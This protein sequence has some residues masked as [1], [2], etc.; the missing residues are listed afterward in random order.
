MTDLFSNTRQFNP[1]DSSVDDAMQSI[2][3]STSLTNLRDWLKHERD[4]RNRSTIIKATSAR[5]RRL[6]KPAL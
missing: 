4:G 1:M 5:I 6:E 2:R 3:K